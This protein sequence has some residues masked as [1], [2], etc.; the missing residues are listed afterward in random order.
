MLDM[1]L[2]QGRQGIILEAYPTHGG[3][4]F[5]PGVRLRHEGLW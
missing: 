3:L 2:A 4:E 1:G 5:Q